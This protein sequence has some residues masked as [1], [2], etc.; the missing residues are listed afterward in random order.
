MRDEKKFLA[1]WICGQLD[2]SSYVFVT[3]FSKVTV[4]EVTE[5]RRELSKESG[6]FHVIKN[7]ILSAVASE[8]LLPISEAMLCGQNAI[9]V[10]GS[11]PSGIAKIIKKFRKSSNGEK[12]A[13]KGGVLDNI[14]LSCTD[15]DALAELPSIEVLRSQLLS[16]FNTPAQQC[17]RALN[18]VP[19][20]MLNVLRA[21]AE[22]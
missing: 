3:D 6:E 5:L 18:A 10:G 13:V 12:F 14:G 21:K 4:K 11:N 20:G 16:M 19:Q 1:K 8:R 17:V 15:V 2:K 22:R 7:S 9:V